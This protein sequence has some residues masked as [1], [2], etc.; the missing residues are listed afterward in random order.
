MESKAQPNLFERPAADTGR[1]LLFALG[2]FQ[3]RGFELGGRELPLDRLLGAFRRAF[4][5]SGRELPSDERVA[6]ALEE[7]GARIERV[8]SYVAKHP[9]RINVPADLA[10]RGLEYYQE[11]KEEKE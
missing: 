1:I 8:P 3:T 10:R 11:Q 5:R 2:D 9:F 4:A 6:E 7:L